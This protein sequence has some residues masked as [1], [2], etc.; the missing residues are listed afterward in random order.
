MGYNWRQTFWYAPEKA[1]Y[2]LHGRSGYLF[3]FNPRVPR[4]DVL[5]RLSSEPS[6]RSGMY[7]SFAYGYLGFALGPDG[8]T[9]YY[10]TTGPIR[11]ALESAGGNGEN[12]GPREDRHL[13]TY[14]IPTGKYEDHGA[15]FLEDGQ[16]P[17][18]VQSIAL[19]KDRTVYTLASFRRNG[20]AI[21]DLIR[22][23]VK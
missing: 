16:R 17:T 23:R 7:D 8:R 10:L 1:I 13:V 21:T 6:K 20:H 12:R 11:E 2:A 18:L 4:V 3:R 14:D 5:D 9:V 22:I 19:T 15:I